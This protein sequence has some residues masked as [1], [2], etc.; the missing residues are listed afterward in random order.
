MD[1]ADEL[2]RRFAEFD[3]VPISVQEFLA[4]AVRR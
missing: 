1:I 3:V 2:C 4:A